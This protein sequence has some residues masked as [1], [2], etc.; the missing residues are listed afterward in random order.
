VVHQVERN[1]IDNGR[2]WWCVGPTMPEN[3]KQ[4]PYQHLVGEA[5]DVA[6]TKTVMGSAMASLSLSFSGFTLSLF[7]TTS[8][9]LSLSLALSLCRSL[10][11]SLCFLSLSLSR[12]MLPRDCQKSFLKCH[13]HKHPTMVLSPCLFLSF[14]FLSLTL[15]RSLARSLALSLSFF[16]SSQPR[17]HRW[18]LSTRAASEGTGNDSYSGPYARCM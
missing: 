12:G 3:L 8:L 17:R 14:R 2:Y 16:L 13:V 18:K 15:C 6:W 9:S 10:C 5:V 1:G 7:L 4:N 11:R